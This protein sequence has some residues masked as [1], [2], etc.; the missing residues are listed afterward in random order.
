MSPTPR[1][2]VA[3]ALV[4]LQRA[5]TPEEVWLA[6]QALLRAA[7]P[8]HYELIGLPSL[9][10]MPFFLRTTMPTRDIGRF[11]QLAPLNAVIATKPG[12][13]VARMSDFYTAAPG[14]PFFEEFLKPDGW[15]YAAALLFWADDGR[16]IGQLAT[17][18]SAEQGDFTDAELAGLRLLHPQVNAAVVRLLTQ[19]NAAGTQVTLEHSLH[20]LPLPIAIVTWDLT[21]SFTNRAAT[22]TIH[23]WRHGAATARAIKAAP[24]LPGNLTAACVTLK[25]AW[26]SAVTTH[27]FS[28]LK[29]SITL[30]NSLTDGLSATI[31]LVESPAG[32][33]LHPSFVIHFELPR[34]PEAEVSRALGQFALLT[35]GE[36]A[37]A[38]LAAEGHDNA[39]IARQLN[40][41]LSTVRTHLRNIFRKLGITTRSRLAPLVHGL[42]R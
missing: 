12:L 2:E 9:G 33:T 18:R 27:D 6:T 21:L 23:R 11:G 32:R 5:I 22:E 3:P 42:K 39:A 24:G 25:D 19:E 16:F 10:I 8:S 1:P 35:P 28:R 40:R 13:I 14:D 17:L 4:A 29:R 20:A 15:L 38:I 36:R 37:I 26:N 7:T 30:M 41:S 31:R 34:T